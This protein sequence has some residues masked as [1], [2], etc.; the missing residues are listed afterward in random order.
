MII[1]TFN[2]YPEIFRIYLNKCKRT[3]VEF[4]GHLLPTTR[5]LPRTPD[6]QPHT[7]GQEDIS[8]RFICTLLYVFEER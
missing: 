6:N 4:V 8:F 2:Q 1:K 7:D 3:N 5:Y